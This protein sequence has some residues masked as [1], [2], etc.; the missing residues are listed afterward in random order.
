MEST[1]NSLL[2][3]HFFSHYK[4]YIDICA[5]LCLMSVCKIIMVICPLLQI[6]Y[7]LLEYFNF[8][9]KEISRCHDFCY[10]PHLAGSNSNGVGIWEQSFQPQDSLN[11]RAG[12]KKKQHLE[13]L[14]CQITGNNC[15]APQKENSSCPLGKESVFYLVLI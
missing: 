6:I 1:I 11:F 7:L 2:F 13:G 10:T 12:E 15:N 5:F 9:L 4:C 3:L 8:F 14:Y